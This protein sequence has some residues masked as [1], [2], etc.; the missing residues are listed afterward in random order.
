VNFL[1]VGKMDGLVAKP[2]EDDGERELRRQKEE[3][4]VLM[5]RLETLE[6]Q[7]AAQNAELVHLREKVP[8]LE[9]HISRLTPL[10]PM[11]A[12]NLAALHAPAA[13]PVAFSA[14]G[15]G[16]MVRPPWASDVGGEAGRDV[17]RDEPIDGPE[18]KGR[19]ERRP[20]AAHA[21]EGAPCICLHARA[22]PF[23]SLHLSLMPPRKLTPA[24]SAHRGR[25]KGSYAPAKLCQHQIL[26]SKCP[27]CRVDRCANTCE[28]EVGAC[29]GAAHTSAPFILQAPDRCRAALGYVRNAATGVRRSARTSGHSACAK[30]AA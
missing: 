26:R 13:G 10:I 12:P 18:Q 16:G 29:F 5:Q 14:G 3:N 9:E 19:S 24:Q 8:E 11:V 23:W 15:D 27:E 4:R 21:L 6:R 30:S 25:P 1:Q 28:P 17:D 2:P 7:L 20:R 22:V